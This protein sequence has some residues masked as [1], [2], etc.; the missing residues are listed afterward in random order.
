[1]A[2]NNTF[3]SILNTMLARVPTSID[4]REGSFIYDS[5]AP[6]AVELQNMYIQSD[7]VLNETF[8]DTASRENLIRRAAER[9]ITIQPATNAIVKGEFTP[10]TLE[11]PIGSRFSLD[12]FNYSVTEKIS[13]GIY[14]L[15]CEETGADANFKFGQLIPIDYINGLQYAE[16][17][18]ILIPGEDEESTESLR[19]RYFANLENQAFGGNIT[20]YKQKVNSLSGI[21]GVKVYPVWNGGGTVKLVIINSDFQKPS[22]ELISATQT[23]ID[24][25]QNQGQGLGIAPIGHVVTVIGVNETVLNIASEFTLQSGYQWADVEANIKS[26]IQNYFD[27]LNFTW[28]DSENLIVR[29]SQLETRLLNLDGII[30]IANTKINNTTENFVLNADSI[31][32]LGE[33]NNI[34]T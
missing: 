4:K 30:D 23:A 13:D 21:G 5:L 14:K 19:K 2:E 28:A 9:G 10:N 3:E 17:T 1:M 7:Y 15:Q 11:I 22:D 27:E 16:I 24:P 25:I 26:T 34:A 18:S 6:T 12:E 32:I 20:D 33:V 29:I 31:A 8:A